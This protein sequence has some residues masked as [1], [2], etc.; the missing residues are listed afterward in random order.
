V[1]AAQ[2]INF[3]VVGGTSGHLLGGVLAAALLGPSA[4]VI[5]ISAV[6]VVQCLVFADGGITALGA[7]VFNMALVGGVGGWVVYALLSRLAK[8]AVARIL[9]AAVAAWASTVLASIACA[10]ELAASHTVGWSAGFAAMAGVHALIGLG[11]GLITA[12]VLTAIVS[13]RPDLLGLPGAAAPAAAMQRERAGTLL[14]FGLLVSLGLAM[15]VAPFACPWPD[16]LDKTA[17]ALGFKD[18]ETQER[19]AAAPLA[20]YRMPG[21]ASEGVATGVAGAAGT[22]VV[23]GLAWLVA[24]T[25]V[26]KSRGR[27]AGGAAPLPQQGS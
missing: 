15:F 7:N 9:A 3:P 1:F 18:K 11:E 17:A 16:G 23:F 24:R 5:V 27:D 4:A 26:R 19:G 10:G 20:D 21:V 14:V 22:V 8:G 12:L 25:L 2:M 13:V 6:L